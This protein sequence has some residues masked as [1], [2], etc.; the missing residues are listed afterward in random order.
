MKTKIWGVITN[1]AK[2]VTKYLTLGLLEA[3][4]SL[5]KMF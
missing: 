5:K 4:F 2:Y 1:K 3:E